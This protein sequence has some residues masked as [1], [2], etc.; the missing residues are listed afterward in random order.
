MNG[1][2]VIMME[3]PLINVNFL[4][5]YLFLDMK[6][7]DFPFSLGFDNF[8]T[9]YHPYLFTDLKFILVL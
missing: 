6:L 5:S 3:I 2:K 1:N 8:T 9:G 4:D 7:A